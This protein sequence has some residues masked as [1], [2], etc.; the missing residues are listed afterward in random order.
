MAG[1][2]TS[3]KPNSANV[4]N[5]PGKNYTGPLMVVTLLFFMWGFITCM[6]DILIPKLQ[7]VFTLQNW[8]AMLIQTA[9]FGAY[10]VVSL[11]YYIVSVSKGDPIARIGYKN[12]IIVALLVGA[13]GCALFFPA[14]TNE[15]FSLFLTALFVLASGMTVLQIAAN[16]YVTILGPPETGSSRLSMAGAF[17]SLG[18]TIAPV[19]GG[20]LIF[21]GINAVEETQAGAESVQLPYLALAGMLIA[22]AVV[23]K[24]F[25]LPKVT[26]DE[27][28]PSGSG[29]LQYRHLVLGIICIFMYVGGE[30][31]VGSFLINYMKLPEIANFD[32]TT[33]SLF[34]SLYWGGAM[35]G[36]FFGAVTLGQK[37]KNSKRY[38]IMASI[39]AITFLVVFYA[40]GINVALITLGLIALN[41]VVL[42]L[43]R[44][45]P[46]RTLGIFAATVVGLLL[47]TMF[48]EGYISMWSA[49]AIGLFN[50]IM[51]PT[52]FA[53]A[54]DK[55]GKYTSQGSSLLVMA[56]VGGAIVPPIQGYVAD[57]SN[58]QFSFVVPIICYLYIMFYG[59]I[60][61]KP[62]P[63]ASK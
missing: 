63:A 1:I 59:F 7:V 31:T 15:S 10:F 26:D 21:G 60:G 51:W 49:I 52:I 42:L 41:I 39:S 50:S 25:K 34:L 44:F 32:E 20:Y 13:V 36:R 33:A 27:S 38:L 54:I 12:A 61:S 9:F 28:I 16:P 55:L 57:I 11:I 62:Q 53:L 2:T 43:G 22:L 40:F 23:F 45:I 19:I 58:I 56:V 35:I 4:Q 18:T 37:K 47:I 14:A 46:S 6:N 8:E 30:V 24:M 17:N 48:A 5:D 3:T 29:A